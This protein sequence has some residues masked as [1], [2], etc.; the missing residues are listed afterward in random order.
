MANETAVS[1][2]LGQAAGT[3]TRHSS[4]NVQYKMKFNSSTGKWEQE[5]IMTPLVQT[6]YPGIRTKEGKTK[7]I[8]T[9]LVSQP[10]TQPVTTQPT[11]PEPEVTPLPTMTSGTRTTG[12]G[13]YQ[14]VRRQYQQPIGMTQVG[15]IKYEPGQIS[16]VSE[17]QRDRMKFNVMPGG[18]NFR[19]GA[20]N[21]SLSQSH[22]LI[23]DL[24]NP[25]AES[26]TEKKESKFKL[27]GLLGLG[28]TIASTTLQPR[29]EKLQITK[30]IEAGALQVREGDKLLSNKEAIE[31]LTQDENGR[32]KILKG[33]DLINSGLKVTQVKRLSKEYANSA[34]F[35][36]FQE[37]KAKNMNTPEGVKLTT[38][39]P[40]MGT[41]GTTFFGILKDP[42][43][44]SSMNGEQVL[45]V[46]ANGGGAFRSDGKFVG[47][48]GQVYANGSA[49]Q[50]KEAVESGHIPLALLKK[51]TNKD[52]SFKNL[53]VTGL[54]NEKSFVGDFT[55]DT[56][57]LKRVVVGGVEK[58]YYDG[59]LVLKN[60]D[61]VTSYDW[62]TGE[63][64]NPIANIADP[65]GSD[66]RY[67]DF[68]ENRWE[69]PETPTRE[70]AETSIREKMKKGDLTWKKSDE[71][72]E[73]EEKY[74]T[75]SQYDTSGRGGTGQQDKKDD[76]PAE[77]KEPKPKEER[78][79][80]FHP[81][82]LIGNKFIKD[83]QPGDLINGIEIIGMVKLKLNE[84]MYSL[85]DVRVTGTH[86][87]KYNN[88][89]I[90]VFNHPDSFRIND[91]PEFVYVPIVKGGI[92]NINNNEFADYDDEHIETLDNKLKVA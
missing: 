4:Q 10:E 49:A 22:G 42:I 92:F 39:N 87:V 63:T 23:N 68:I 86:K 3:A 34:P 12:G 67:D 41:A 31:R 83:L 1:T 84:P 30:M 69:K 57:Y 2:A 58:Y 15:G 18:L 43:G 59:N 35:V 82:Q 78:K 33:Q 76:K 24:V 32:T 75:P 52:G 36:N 55:L 7:D 38:L 26:E 51:M 90:Y 64:G 16:S 56:K 44:A 8:S 74:P 40:V 47:M 71:Q 65:D 89:W 53:Y 81:E 13:G 28:Q 29:S 66:G 21:F 88:N 70:E 91:K 5:Q 62:T 50:A 19:S 6:I 54:T 77:K 17:S 72:K 9:G 14:D 45:V 27:P 37:D 80:C 73:F 60:G 85:N 61:V 48:N 46:S 20:Q 79:T 25:Q 11:T